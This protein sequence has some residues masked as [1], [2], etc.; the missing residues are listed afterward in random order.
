M[1]VLFV[2]SEMEPLFK[3]GGLGDVSQSLPNA[4]HK[5]NVDVTVIIPYYTSIK[6]D[7]PLCLGKL[8]VTYRNEHH[9]VFVFASRHPK[10][11]VPV[12]LLRHPLF[13]DYHDVTIVGRFAFYSLAVVALTSQA[14]MIVGHDIDIIHCHDWH[15]A[16]VPLLASENSKLNDAHTST[17]TIQAKKS[18]TILTIHN[19]LY[20]GITTDTLTKEIGLPHELVHRLNRRSGSFVNLMREGISYADVVTTVSPTYARE[21]YTK[22]YGEGL[23]GLFAKRKDR[24]IGILNGIDREYWNPASDRSLAYQYDSDSILRIKPKLKNLLQKELTL[25][26]A[27]IPLL[28]YIGRLD[29][30]QKGVNILL[31]SI[32]PF[33]QKRVC[34]L[35]ILGT[36]DKTIVGMI[37]KLAKVYPGRVTFTHAFDE[38]LARR[39]YA[40][41]DVVVIP[42]KFEPCGLI[43][44]IAMRY[45]TIPLVRKTGGLADSVIDGKTGIVFGPYT[46]TALIQSIQKAINIYHKSPTWN[47]MVRRVMRQDF[48]WKR[49]A[50]KYKQLYLRLLK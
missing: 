16:L 41:A 39:I 34:Q 38:P 18:H 6:L 13:N 4:L 33:L 30:H 17:E 25:D 32:K 7:R 35:A 3:L 46:M 10:N 27:D 2:T 26:P 8:G 44:M 14:R 21:I 37:G 48:S 20:Q 19:L 49:S 31:T 28:A 43:Q 12:L 22:E 42:S 29:G 50:K 36:G 15:S 9:L 5:L 40:G 1:H 45:G 47:Q 24:V 11:A 23:E